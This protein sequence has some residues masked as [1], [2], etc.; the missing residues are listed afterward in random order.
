[1]VDSSKRRFFKRN[2][3]DET[4]VRLPWIAR[5]SNFTDQCTRCNKCLDACETQI[6]TIQ[7]GGFPTVDFSVDE[8]TF[9]YQCAAVC[10]EPIFNPESELPWEATASI[11]QQCLAFKNVEC[12]SCSEMCETSAIR[13]QIEIGKVA[14][15]IIDTNECTGCGGCVSVCPTSAIIVTNTRA[16]NQLTP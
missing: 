13:F 7:D 10:P 1:M 2:A 12:R 3:V 15:P 4:I 5:P 11:N 16:V 8:C 9:C 14:Q 6:I